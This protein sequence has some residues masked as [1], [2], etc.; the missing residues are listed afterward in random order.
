MNL[1]GC[2]KSDLVCCVFI[3]CLYKE[4]DDDAVQAALKS[5]LPAP[6]VKLEPEMDDASN[7]LVAST[8][9]PPPRPVATPTRNLQNHAMTKAEL[10]PEPD[11]SIHKPKYAKKEPTRQELKPCFLFQCQDCV[12][13]GS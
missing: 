10:A 11:A 1:K 7:K 13:L 8:P 2:V 9:P 12:I 3:Q 6:A 4:M 5:I